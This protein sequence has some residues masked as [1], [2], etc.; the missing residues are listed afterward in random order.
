MKS[1]VTFAKIVATPTLT[2]WSQAYNAGNLAAVLSLTQQPIENTDKEAEIEDTLSLPALGKELLNTLEAEYFTL[3]TKNLTTI[4]QAITTTL[5]KVTGDITVSFCVSVIMESILY[6]CIF[7]KGK[8][9]MKRQGKLGTLLEQQEEGKLTSASGYLE[10]EDIVILETPQFAEIVSNN[11]L[12][13]CLSHDK[14][15]EMADILSPVIHEQQNG[16]ASAIAFSYREETPDTSDFNYPVT[17]PKEES[18]PEAV[19][20]EQQTTATKTSDAEEHMTFSVEEEKDDIVEESETDKPLEGIP[21]P[22]IRLPHSKRLFITIAVIIGIVLVASIFFSI[23]KQK[24]A[25]R[26]ALYASTVIP[27]Q[28]KYDEGQS[29][30]DL[31]KNVA[32]DDFQQAKTMLTDALPKFPADSKEAKDAQTLMKKIDDA[33]TAAAQITST[34]A[35][36]VDASSSPLLSALIKHASAKYAVSDDKNIYIADNTGVT[37]INKNTE[38]ESTAIKNTDAWKSIGGLGTYLGNFYI[39]DTQDGIL[40]YVASG[41]NFSKSNYFSGTAPDLSKAQGITI[42]GSIWIINSD[43]TISKFTKG[44]ADEFS[45]KGL[46]KAFTNPTRI[47]TNVDSNTVYI[48]DTG[49]KRIVLLDKKGN[50]IAQ[51]QS[52]VLGTAQDFDVVEKDKKIYVLSSGKVYQMELK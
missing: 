27:A 3:E 39:L 13:P 24:D 10:N 5:E 16:A 50:Y 41:T 52:G 29:L 6:L 2:S 1:P 36:P 30:M 49:N 18:A 42:D 37:A 47:Y 22:K 46:D 4:K 26:Q 51:Y 9:L 31:N 17:K 8:I 48:L 38:K 12:L 20:E 11:V 15:T 34:T 45:I 7:G 28:K 19:N 21:A 14:L 25:A 43:G 32:R 40:K 23:S 44:K 33:L 35:T